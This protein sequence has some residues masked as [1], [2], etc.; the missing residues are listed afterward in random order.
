MTIIYHFVLHTNSE[1]DISPF[2]IYTSDAIIS[3]SNH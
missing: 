2:D 3:Q 1:I